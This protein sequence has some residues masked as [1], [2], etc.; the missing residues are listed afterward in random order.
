MRRDIISINVNVHINPTT[1][2]YI[3]H[4]SKLTSSTSN[5]EEKERII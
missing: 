1:F 3:S 5:Q 4:D 2:N